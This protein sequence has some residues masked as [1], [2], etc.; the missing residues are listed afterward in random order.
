MTP[1][2][3]ARPPRP[4]WGRVLVGC[5]IVGGL[6]ILAGAAVVVFGMYWLTTPGRHYAT[7]AVASPQSQGVIRVG[8]LAADPGA[9]ALL[10]T[11]F[12][13]MQEAQQ[14]EGQPQLPA[15]MRNLQ[16]QQARQ[17]ISQWLPR[18]AT[19]TMEPDAEAVPRIVLAANMRGFVQ[20]IRLAITQAMKGDRKSSITRHGKHEVL[21]FGSD[22]SLCFMDGTLVVSYHPSVMTPALDRLAEAGSSPRPPDE[23]GLPGPWDATGWLDE[24]TGTGV[25]VGLLSQSDDPFS[26]AGAPLSALRDIRF[27]IDVESA[28][29]ALVTT[30]IAFT[31]AEGAAAAQ[32]WLAEGVARLRQ[33]L[34]SSGL[35]STVT[36]SMEGDRVRYEV[37]LTGLEAAFVRMIERHERT[38]RERT[39]P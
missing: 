27:G 26:G 12:K 15:W 35:G 5:A 36:D 11:F 20:P 30:Q 14:R 37:R 23:R 13:R 34:E 10:T 19:V 18:E 25:L 33:R 29:G 39:D 22:T 3:A 32:P 16:A 7:T 38:R 28:D 1:L 2:P 31:D 17:G 8:D 4:I 9:R 21:N 6:G 24:A